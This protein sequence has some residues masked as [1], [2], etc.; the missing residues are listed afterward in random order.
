MSTVNRALSLLPLTVLNASL[1]VRGLPPEPLKANAIYTIEGLVNQGLLSL[2]DV[3]ASAPN[4]VSRLATSS[5]AV[6]DDV[7]AQVVS[8]STDV[9]ECFRSSENVTSVNDLASATFNKLLKEL[10]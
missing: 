6:P 4:N 7:R 3:R 5:S 1:V 9:K 2:D 10:Q 8:A